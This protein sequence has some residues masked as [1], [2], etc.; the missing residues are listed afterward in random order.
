MALHFPSDTIVIHRRRE[1]GPISPRFLA[2]VISG[3]QRQDRRYG[4]E[5]LGTEDVSSLRIS[6]VQTR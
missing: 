4:E 1:F 2:L 5:A 6:R 3:Q